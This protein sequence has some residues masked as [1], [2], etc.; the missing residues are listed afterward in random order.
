V[1]SEI[2]VYAPGVTPDAAVEQLLRER[3]DARAAKDFKASDQIR[4]RLAQLGYAIKD[5]PGGKVEVRR[6]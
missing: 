5:M 1:T 3:R 2:G 4:D 6:A